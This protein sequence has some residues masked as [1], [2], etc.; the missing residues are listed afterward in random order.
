MAE[1]VCIVDG[2]QSKS[3]CRQM[4]YKHYGRWQRHGDP[5]KLVNPWGTP[6]ERLWRHVDRR[7]PDDCW[8]W[9]AATRYGY[10]MV[11]NVKERGKSVMAHRFAYELLVGP[12]PDGL[13]LM[14]KCDNPPCCNPAHLTPGTPKEN[15]HDMM[16]KGRGNWRAPKGE[17]SPRAKLTAEQAKII[18][19]GYEKGVVLAA[20]FGVQPTT[21][22]AIRNGRLW[23]EI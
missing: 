5:E 13:H 4:C 15:V 6:E 3:A 12:I 21:V 17:E 19:Y 20:R 11:Q 14:H 10:G 22:S 7:G 18:K 1:K 9:Q 8:E 23:K 16:A 2:C